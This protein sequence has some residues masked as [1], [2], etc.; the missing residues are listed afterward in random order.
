MNDFQDFKK[1]VAD[2][3]KIKIKERGL[4]FLEIAKTPN[5]EIV[6][7]NI[8]AFYLNP[9]NEHQLSDLLLKSILGEDFV[10]TN[11]NNISVNTEHRTQKNNRIDILV[12]NDNFILGIENKVDALS[13]NDFK[14]YSETI[15][16]LANL[17]NRTPYKIILS[18]YPPNPKI[19]FGFKNVLYGDF[20]KN[21]KNNLGNYTYHADSKYLLFLLDF[22]KNIEN[23]LNTQNMND[24]LEVVNFF[25]DNVLQINRLMKE[26]YVLHDEL[27]D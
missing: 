6:W 15:D 1:L 27:V 18:K 4:T 9:N 26:H 11:F 7:T 21:L 20:V 22:I 16:N 10:S 23:S 12:S 19:E 17:R 8:L 3:S 14:D 24:K 5:L 25:H 13:Y 2:F